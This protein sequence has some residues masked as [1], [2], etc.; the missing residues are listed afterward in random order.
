MNEEEIKIGLYYMIEVQKTYLDIYVGE[1]YKISLNICDERLPVLGELSLDAYSLIFNKDKRELLNMIDIYMKTN[2]PKYTCGRV[3]TNGFANDEFI[4]DYFVNQ[5]ANLISK[6]EK[7]EILETGGLKLLTSK[8]GKFVGLDN[9]WYCLEGC[10]VPGT[11]KDFTLQDI[12]FVMSKLG[13]D[14]KSD[15]PKVYM[16]VIAYIEKIK[17]ALIVEKIIADGTVTY[18]ITVPEEAMLCE[19][20]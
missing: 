17:S 4:K 10:A 11:N 3:I 2:P 5:Q 19:P 15:N 20:K 7:Q 1:D 13:N 14:F 8:S 16:D 18:N 9:P 12:F 6:R